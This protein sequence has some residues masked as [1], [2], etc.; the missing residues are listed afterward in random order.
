MKYILRCLGILKIS[1]RERL[2]YGFDFFMSIVSTIGYGILYFFLWRS[3]Y[4]YST[5]I[6]MQWS[7]LITYIMVAQA[8]NMTRYSASDRMPVHKM[9]SYIRNGDIALDLLRPVDFH[10]RRFLES[11]G[12]FVVDILWINIPVYLV[13]IIFLGI[14]PPSSF[15]NGIAFAF[16]IIIGYLLSFAINSMVLMLA[17]FTNNTN[18]IQIAKQAVIGFLAGPMIPFEFFPDWLRGFAEVLPFQ[19]MAHIPISIY[20]GNSIG[21]DILWLLAN[22]MVWTIIMLVISRLIWHRAAKKITIYGG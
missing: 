4:S 3:I 16:S 12:Y 2:R 5:N 14:N 22:Q 17:F 11:A 7:D 15:I 18:G 9:N 13:F 10:L 6:S 21:I 20:T 1:L 19:G 8:M